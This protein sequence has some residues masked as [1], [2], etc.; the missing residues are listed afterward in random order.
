MLEQ[1]ATIV[2]PDTILRWRRELVAGQ[3]GNRLIEPGKEVG[4]S[5]GDLGRRKRLGGM[6]R[7]CCRQAA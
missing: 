2:I 3:P 6:L 4:R 7:Y 1:S 5:A